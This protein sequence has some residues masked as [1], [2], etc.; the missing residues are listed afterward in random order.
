LVYGG[1]TVITC[2]N[3]QPFALWS[4]RWFDPTLKSK[5]LISLEKNR[6]VAL[7][8]EARACG[9][10]KGMSHLAARSMSKEVV[11]V[12]FSN[13][14]LEHQ[15]QTLLRQLT[16]YTHLL[17][18]PHC[19]V[20]FADL[21]ASDTMR[22][23]KTF[24]VRCG[25]GETQESS[26]LFALSGSVGEVRS[27]LPTHTS[28]KLFLELGVSANVLQRL[29]YLGIKTVGQLRKWKRNQ[30][31]DSLGKES[32]ILARYLFGPFRR[33]VTPYTPPLRLEVH[34]TFDESVCEPYQLEPVI[35]LLSRRLEL[36]LQNRVA[37][38]ITLVAFAS[39]IPF[40]ETRVVRNPIAG[41]SLIELHA[42][43]LL[44]QSPAAALGIDRLELVLE[45]IYRFNEQPSL[46]GNLRQRDEAARYVS[47]RSPNALYK[48][49]QVDEFSPLPEFAWKLVPLSA[50]LPKVTP[51]LKKARVSKQLVSL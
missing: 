44:R 12:D 22:L 40:P 49:E 25:V 46:F 21:A 7:T 23:A 33:D 17:E 29:E 39:G 48:F 35:S 1:D 36:G 16:S 37:A 51:A 45:D 8:R 24:G 27:K 11:T 32:S 2:L 20:V 5:P 4:A 28:L 14:T 42:L 41:A 6:V 13:A 3:F 31:H 30:L 9:I 15:W 50:D 34:Y 47:E 38:R 19:G 18:S 10:S 43:H 26:H